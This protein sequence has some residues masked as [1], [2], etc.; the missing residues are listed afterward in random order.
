M[1]ARQTCRNETL[2]A[3]AAQLTFITLA[4]KGAALLGRDT[5]AG[6]LHRTAVF[7]SKNALQSQ[8]NESRKRDEFETHFQSTASDTAGGTWEEI[9]PLLAEALDALPSKD[10]DAL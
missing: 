6:W 1:A 2:A 5:L 9:E 8:R 7:H 4:R 3:D 10:R